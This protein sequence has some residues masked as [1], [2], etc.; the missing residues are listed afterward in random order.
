MDAALGM[1]VGLG[2][3]AVV[4]AVFVL[5]AR[6]IRR[7]GA[8]ARLMGPIDEVFHPGAHRSRVEIQIADER[9]DPPAPSADAPQR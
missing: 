7:S 6:R 1:L 4:L 8:G 9:A 2:S 5:L 3:F